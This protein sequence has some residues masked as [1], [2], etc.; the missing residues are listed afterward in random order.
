MPVAAPAQRD[1]ATHVSAHLLRQ[2]LAPKPSPPQ[3]FVHSEEVPSFPSDDFSSADLDYAASISSE[4]GVNAEPGSYFNTLSPPILNLSPNLSPAESQ[5]R[6]SPVYDLRESTRRRSHHQGGRSHSN[7]RERGR[8]QFENR[9]QQVGSC[10]FFAV[11]EF[12]GRY[13]R[14]EHDFPAFHFCM[15]TTKDVAL[16]SFCGNIFHWLSI[17]RS[18]YSV[19]IVYSWTLRFGE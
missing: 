18:S 6:G 7:R 9:A 4:A 17:L 10:F 8:S 12:S 13:S 19:C 11:E 15:A 5:Q 1:S 3:G 14:Q 16:G 2:H